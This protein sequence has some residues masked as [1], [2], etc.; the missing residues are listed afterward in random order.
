M[1]LPL[2][3]TA[4][5]VLPA[6]AGTLRGRVTGPAGQPLSDARVEVV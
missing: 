1:M 2:L 6:D 3:L 4:L 5:A